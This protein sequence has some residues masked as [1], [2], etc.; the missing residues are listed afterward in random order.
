MRTVAALGAAL[1]RVVSRLAAI[2]RNFGLD[3]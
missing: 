2:A 3:H 1:I